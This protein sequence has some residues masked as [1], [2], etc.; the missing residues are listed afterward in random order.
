MIQ[1]SLYQAIKKGFIQ[2]I[3]VTSDDKEAKEAYEV[4]RFSQTQRISSKQ[5]TPILLPELRAKMGDDMRSFA[6]ELYELLHK[7]REFYST[8]NALL[9]APVSSLL[10]PLPNQSLLK[11]FTLSKNAP[12]DL[13]T[14]QKTLLFYGYELV[15]VVE[16]EGEMSF[17]G[18]IVDIFVPFDCAYRLSFFDTE[19]ESIRIFDPDSQ[20]S[21]VGEKNSIVIAPALFSLSQEQYENL[22]ELVSHSEFEVF[23]KDIHSLGFWYVDYAQN[24]TEDIGGIHQGINFFKTYSCLLTPNALDEVKEI[25]SF[26]FIS[27]LKLEDF[28]SLPILK[29]ATDGSIDIDVVPKAIDSLIRLN[30]NKQI[31]LIAKNQALFKSIELSDSSNVKQII[32]DC[33]VN[34]CAPDEIIIS[35]NT[36]V[37]AKKRKKPRLGLDELNIGEYVVHN[38][39]GIGIFKGIHQVSILGNVRDFIDIVYQGEDKLLLPVENLHLIDRYISSSSGVPILDRLG[40]G[41]FVKLKEKIREKLFEIADSI[42]KMAAKRSLLEGKKIDISNPEVMAFRSSCGFT[43]TLDQER[44]I[45]EIF[46]DISSGNVMDRLLSGDVGFGKT[47]VALNTI[48]AMYTSGLQ[49]AMIVPTTLLSNQHF[50]TLQDR[51]ASFGVKVAK[52][53]GSLKN[54]QKSLVLQSL[55]KGDIDVVI[56]THS[57]LGA[58]FKNLGL[59][60]IDEEHKFGVKQK[61]ALKELSQ[62]VHLLSMSATPIPRTLNMAL[63]KIKGMSSLLT[64]PIERQG[65][66]TFLKEKSPELLKEVI[67]REL[68]RN[69]QIFYVHNNIATILGVK[70]E[71]KDLIPN[72]K[73]AIL[74]SQVPSNQSEEIMTDFANGKYNLLLCTSIVESG[75]HLPNTNTMIVDGADRFGL[76]DLHQL[77]GRVGRGHKGGF[78]YFLIG[79]KKSLTQEAQKRLLALE[80]NSYL[81]SGEQVAYRDLEI[82]GG[83]NLIG[84]AQS[85]HIKNIGYGLYLKMLEEA[86]NTLSG[87]ISQNSTSV[88]LKLNVS[89]YLNPELISSERLRLELYR[90]L[91]LCK[92][93]SEVYEIEGEI[94]DRFG[95]LDAMSS[96][97][98]Q[99]IMIKI[100]CNAL[101][102]KNISSY[103]QNVSIIYEDDTK[104]KLS[105]ASKDEDDVLNCILSY[106]RAKVKQQA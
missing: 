34:L 77:R 90:R 56:G 84:Q 99:V 2:Q 66:K 37:K 23:S 3:L 63:S 70:E 18:D 39:Y 40:K 8:P 69:G 16:M 35:L 7:L 68:R 11:T 58:R 10:Y 75:I 92:E 104:E 94:E 86:I 38:D 15:D 4:A 29:P 28:T 26:E 14:L 101:K 1:S 105:S 98:L 78:C 51:L 17:R 30:S 21:E 97:F 44:A 55:L 43:L 47:E 20:M 27:S 46:A 93:I 41:S 52:L 71:L 88:E 89:A 76:A 25:F 60:I 65:N 22:S 59:V 72:L 53:D 45:E 32:C 85:G 95:K 83:G 13:S 54:A 24:E 33:V 73:I 5:L 57:L 80:K 87:S 96:Q 12:I 42:I 102:M 100:M 62:D 48:F 103:G 106:L 74:H 36:A 64:P 50:G 6:G 49:S 82:R 91:S 31:L 67:Q 79:E 61:E 19:C 81:G 9:I